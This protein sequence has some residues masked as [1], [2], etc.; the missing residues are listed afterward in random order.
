MKWHGIS[1]L[2]AALF[3]IFACIALA[4]GMTGLYQDAQFAGKVGHTTG[5]IEKVWGS[6]GYRNRSFHATYSYQAGAD[7]FEET[8]AAISPTDFPNL[9]A[10]DRV[11]IKF[12]PVN[13][14]KGRIDWPSEDQW[15]W[16]ADEG[17]L[18]LGILMVFLG[19]F[20]MWLAIPQS[21]DSWEQA[22]MDS[23][24]QLKKP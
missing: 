1:P 8:T 2:R 15:N 24:S 3:V 18:T 14:E 17:R 22:A 10:G 16:L 20:V 9:H 6:S 23:E 11:P 19:A 21:K 5:S 7:Q 12:I 4:S 13:P